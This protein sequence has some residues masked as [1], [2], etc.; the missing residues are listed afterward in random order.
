MG[1]GD[2]PYEFMLF[3]QGVFGKAAKFSDSTQEI[4][5]PLS[6]VKFTRPDP[7]SETCP[8]KVVMPQWLA[9]QKGLIDHGGVRQATITIYCT[10]EARTD[11]ALLLN[12]GRLDEPVWVPRSLIVK[13]GEIN[14]Y[15]QAYV[16]LPEQ[17]ARA[18]GFTD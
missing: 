14:R 15:K 12:D 16:T 9:R 11:H 3:Y 5:L 13:V 7:G 6:L 1:A 8:V 2:Q 18:K 17:I 10:I 4:F